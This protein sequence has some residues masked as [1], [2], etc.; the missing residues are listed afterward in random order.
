MR[1]TNIPQ[2]A[3]AVQASITVSDVKTA[4][5]LTPVTVE[6]TDFHGNPIEKFDD[7]KGVLMHLVVVSNDLQFFDHIHPTFVGQGRFKVNANFPYSGDYTLFSDCQPMGESESLSVLTQTMEGSPAPEVSIDTTLRDTV[8]KDTKVSLHVNDDKAGSK[9]A[10]E[11]KAGEETTLQFELKQSGSGEP[12]KDLRPYLD[13]MGHLVVVRQ[14]TQQP[15][16]LNRDSY[17]HAHPNSASVAGKV[18]F[19]TCFP[20]PGNYK[21][22][23]EFDRGGQKIVADFW[24]SVL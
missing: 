16:I 23:G 17:I 18:S 5:K 4:D 21:L 7:I 13:A 20:E 8:I 11:V 3:N 10:S 12:V 15:P 14:S 24:I 1:K 19:K 22:W 2:Q 6:V 9:D